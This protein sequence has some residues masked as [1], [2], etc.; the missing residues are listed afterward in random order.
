MLEA[1]QVSILAKAIDFVFEQGRLILQERRERRHKQAAGSGNGSAVSE[2]EEPET[3]AHTDRA[4]EESAPALG[5]NKA[6]ALR[7][8][9]RLAS[10][11]AREAEV[12]HLVSLLE[13]QARNYWLAKEQY[14]RW[15]SALVPPIILSNLE[16]AEN[17]VSETT[18]RLNSILTDLY[19][20]RLE[21]QPVS[22]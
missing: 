20:D 7:S 9:I 1:A 14:A 17:S 11:S 2:A 13:I 3:A 8:P 6:E 5:L 10:W 15:G 22:S 4:V 16:E 19:Q 18:S 12:K 21:A